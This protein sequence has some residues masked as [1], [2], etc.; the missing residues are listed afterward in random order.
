[1]IRVRETRR[2]RTGDT[3][4]ATLDEGNRK[5]MNGESGS[6][7]TTIG[8]TVRAGMVLVVLCAL[9]GCGFS[10]GKKEAEA[11]AD[12]YFS[13]MQGGDIEG[14]LSL[15]SAGF[16]EVTSRAE[17]MTLL[18]NQRDRCGAPKTHTLVSWN[19]FNSFGTHAGTRTTLV[20]DV[21]Y[22]SCRMSEKMIIF[23]PDDGVIRIQGHLLKKEP[24]KQEDKAELT[25]KT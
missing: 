23:K 1:M 21:E 7:R 6:K 2:D 16:Y 12:Q 10:Q 11:L 14:A 17:W 20:Y 8:G 13:K 18:E 24:G 9:M 4:F 22:T 15:Y 3:E 19:V 25:L 5:Q